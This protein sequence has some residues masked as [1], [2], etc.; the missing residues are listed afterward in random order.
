MVDV[1][2]VPNA[3]WT[4]ASVMNVNPVTIAVISCEHIHST[5]LLV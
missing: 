2:K 4:D 1:S 3:E 5:D